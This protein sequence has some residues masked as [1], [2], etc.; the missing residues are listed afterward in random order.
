MYK[1]NSSNIEEVGL[2]V[3]E[4]LLA[5]EG[6]IFGDM[7]VKFKSGNTY[8]YEKVPDEVYQAF[9]A[10]ESKGKFFETEIKGVYKFTN[11]TE[12]FHEQVILTAARAKQF[13]INIDAIEITHDPTPI[14]M[15][16]SQSIGDVIG[17]VES[18]KKNEK[19]DLIGVI[20]FKDIKTYDKI[21]KAIK[22]DKYMFTISARTSPLTLIAT[23]II[24][25][26]KE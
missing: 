15:G 25:K 4:G 22:D 24:P 13:G 21:I 23:N 17:K 12:N 20:K 16:F 1:V 18:I 10:S 5:E 8:K 9:L 7:T 14:I 19:G 6:K 3:S 26:E 11:I 2:E